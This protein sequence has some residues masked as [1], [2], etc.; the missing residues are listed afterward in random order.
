MMMGVLPV[1]LIFCIFLYFREEQE[2]EAADDERRKAWSLAD[3]ISTP[4]AQS[5]ARP[6]ASMA[7]EVAGNMDFGAGTTKG[8]QVATEMQRAQSSDKADVAVK[9]G[10]LEERLKGLEG[11]LGDVVLAMRP[12][13]SPTLLKVRKT[14]PLGL[15]LIF[16]EAI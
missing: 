1:L 14:R 7:P 16:F 8:R 5:A 6:G 10:M 11:K 4:E 15:L 9:G 13:K 12:E 3:G 2:E